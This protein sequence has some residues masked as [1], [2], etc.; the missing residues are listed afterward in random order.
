MVVK[1]PK[2]AGRGQDKQLLPTGSPHS[3]E[4][5]ELRTFK[6]PARHTEAK[7]NNLVQ[8]EGKLT[9]PVT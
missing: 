6:I 5:A 3:T 7:A 1:L 9:I 8:K 2:K 4:G